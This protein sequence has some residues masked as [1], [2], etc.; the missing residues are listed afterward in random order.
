MWHSFVPFCTII[1]ILQYYGL[2]KNLSHFSKW[3]FWILSPIF[4]CF[5]IKHLLIIVNLFINLPLPFNCAQNI[6]QFL[7]YCY[8]NL[9]PTL[10]VFDEFKSLVNKK[11][12]FIK[13][14]PQFT[15]IKIRVLDRLYRDSVYDIEIDWW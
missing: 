1:F 13:R 4:C 7:D 5:F 10:P 3:M 12:I 14:S 9:M 11:L 6:V 2:L 8:P 15:V